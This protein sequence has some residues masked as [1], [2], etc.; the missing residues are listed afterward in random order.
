LERNKAGKS[1]KKRLQ[2]WSGLIKPTISGNNK[3]AS[4]LRSTRVLVLV[5]YLFLTDIP[6]SAV[7]KTQFN[8][9]FISNQGS[10]A[11]WDKPAASAVVIL[12]PVQILFRAA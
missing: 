1:G 12:A 9:F 8:I 10:H 3:T 2:E 7:S 4:L 11:V 5:S 6:V